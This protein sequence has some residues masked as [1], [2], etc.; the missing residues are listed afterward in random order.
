M[1]TQTRSIALRTPRMP[2]V[3]YRPSGYYY[4]HR[5]PYVLQPVVE[6]TAFVFSLGTH[7]PKLADI[8]ASEIHA[9]VNRHLYE[10]DSMYPPELT[11]ERAA[12]IAKRW[13]RNK[14]NAD[15]DQRLSAR[16]PTESPQS[17]AE[18]HQAAIHD[19]HRVNLVPHTDMIDAVACTHN[20]NLLS[21]SDEWRRLG[22]YLLQANAELL[23][24][25]ERRSDITRPHPM[26]YIPPDDDEQQARSS[27]IRMSEALEQ[28]VLEEERHP[29]TM[30]EH[31]YKI[32]R[33]NDYAG[34]PYVHEITEGL[35]REFLTEYA[36]MPNRMPKS[37]RARPLTEIVE[38]YE[39]V[40]VP[41]LSPRTIKKALS[42][43]SSLLTWCVEKNHIKENPASGIRLAKRTRKTKRRKRL[44]FT[45][46]DLSAIFEQSPVY[47]TGYRPR[48]GAA[49]AAY[50]LPVL[51]LYTGARLEELGQLTLDD[52]RHEGEI[53]YLDINELEETKSLK[54]DGS[55]RRVPLHEAVLDLGFMSYVEDTKKRGHTDLFPY[56]EALNN[57]RTA[58]F[59]KWVNRH[60][61]LMCKISDTRKVFHSFRHTFKDAAREAGIPRDIRNS[62]MGHSTYGVDEDY[63]VG[64]SLRILNESIQKISYGELTIPPW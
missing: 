5:I 51:A 42:A 22:Y 26:A 27:W 43:V 54:N 13:K 56:V 28:W 44:P 14:L 20:L 61:R 41:R 15:F 6:K 25:L 53:T 60:F 50:W 57:K 12:Q 59:S 24:E 31:R 64:Y 23:K 58:N 36:E 46:S 35:I 39:G 11:H 47:R 3:Q 34:D 16:P 9:T 49:H 52:I 1:A 7:C 29:L 48:G 55:W 18:R 21:E 62:L 2:F 17:L 38:R 45:S 32:R 8:R 33:F 4:R 10:Q 40:D 37:D 63:G 30:K 19:L